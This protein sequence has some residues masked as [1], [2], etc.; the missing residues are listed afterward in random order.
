MRSLFG[1]LDHIIQQAPDEQH[2]TATLNDVDAIV[3]LAEKMDMEIDSDQAISIQQTGLEWL[4][5]YSQG[6]NWDQ[7]REKAQLTLDN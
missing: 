4:K 3:R 2:A 7:C 6:A 5:H 1:I